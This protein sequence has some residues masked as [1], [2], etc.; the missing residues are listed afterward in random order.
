MQS[1]N[2]LSVKGCKNYP[3]IMNTIKC[4]REGN[5]GGGI[6]IIRVK[7]DIQDFEGGLNQ[8]DLINSLQT[9]DHLFD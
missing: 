6:K 7:I 1:A 3:K 4:F 8:D 9:V 2:T 5:Q